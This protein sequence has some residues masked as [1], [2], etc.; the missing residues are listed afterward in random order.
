MGRNPEYW[1]NPEEFFPER[2]KDS[3]IDFSGNQN[4]EYTPFGGGRRICPGMNTAVVLVELVLANVLYSFDWEFPKGL[5]NDLNKEELAGLGSRYPL[6][7]VPIKH[8]V[9]KSE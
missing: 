7:L 3:S 8:V 5:K 2:F 9:K 1:K 4:F 6:D